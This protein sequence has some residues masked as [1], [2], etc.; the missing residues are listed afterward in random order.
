MS[1]MIDRIRELLLKA[2]EIL[3][4]EEAS[5]DCESVDYVSPIVE[6]I[7]PLLAVEEPKCEKVEIKPDP[8]VLV[9]EDD[10]LNF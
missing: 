3:E 6:S 1:K 9:E 2:L 10:F 8:I 4:I 5:D 7:K